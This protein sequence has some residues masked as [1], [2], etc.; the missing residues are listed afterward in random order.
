MFTWV[1]S[2]STCS[3]TAFESAII[4]FLDICFR[5]LLYYLNVFV[6]RC[7]LPCLSCPACPISTD[8]SRLISSYLNTPPLEAAV[9]LMSTSW[10]C[11]A[12]DPHEAPLPKHEYELS[13]ASPAICSSSSCPSSDA[14]GAPRLRRSSGNTPW[15]GHF[16]KDCTVALRAY[17]F[18]VSFCWCVYDVCIYV[19]MSCMHACMYVYK[20]WCVYIHIY[21]WYNVYIYIYIQHM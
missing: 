1:R 20:V 17:C 19:C 11:G 2:Q 9:I 8:Y 6:T 5:T 14:T 13:P 16:P 7:F 12:G 21:I 10:L 15:T 18:V 4:T 3:H